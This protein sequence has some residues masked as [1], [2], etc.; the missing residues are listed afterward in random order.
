MS[1]P[2]DAVDTVTTGDPALRFLVIRPARGGNADTVRAYL[3]GHAHVFL[4]L[5]QG[6]GPVLLVCVA[7]DPKTVQYLTQYQVD[8]L[9]SGSHRVE[10][11]PTFEARSERQWE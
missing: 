11:F 5:N 2:A 9:R 4:E 1:T 7:A 8:R 3:Y 6:W 10:E